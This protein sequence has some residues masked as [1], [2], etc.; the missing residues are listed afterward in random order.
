MCSVSL[1]IRKNIGESCFLKGRCMGSLIN[2]FFLVK[3]NFSRDVVI[4]L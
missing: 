3:F 1:W 2:A 4:Q